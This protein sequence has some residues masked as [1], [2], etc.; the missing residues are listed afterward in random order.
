MNSRSPACMHV[1]DTGGP[2]GAE[3]V[4]SQLASRL[5]TVRHRS[6]TVVPR[7]GWLSGQLR[8]LG[9]EFRVLSRG[10]WPD[11]RYLSA[12]VR[13]ARS[14]NVRMVHSHLLGSCVYAGMLGLG[15]SLPVLGVFHGPTDFRSPGHFAAAKR[16]LIRRGVRRF[17]AVSRGTLDALAAFGVARSR[18]EVIPNGVDTAA[19]APVRAGAL[20][21]ELG[22]HDAELL[23]G[24]VGNIRAPKGYD[25]LLNTA[26][27]VLQQLSNA[28]FAIV[29]EGSERDL[30]P[31]HELRDALGIGSRVHFLGFR[32]TTAALY[33]DF[34]LFV[35]SSRSEGLPLSFLEAM[36][37]GRC[38][39]ATDSGGAKEV[40]ES[41]R[42]G[43]R[44]PIEN[45]PALAAA[46]I[47]L[48][49]DADLRH[50]LGTAGR[51][52]VLRRFSLNSTVE[53]YQQI[54]EELLDG[55]GRTNV[56]AT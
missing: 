23:I 56:A 19:F 6:I 24:S 34:D 50:R 10:G 22:L 13:L 3:T 18:I 43:L 55:A 38:V 33:C 49:R 54:Y 16:W 40:I 44:T 8:A 51:E 17:I 36:A 7:E 15:L 12:L 14:E 48:A 28:H 11:F 1:I 21:A 27:L 26:A 9:I 30:R 41:Q 46:I 35:S 32:K 47:A 53:R 25:V 31:L 45:P 42:T 20:R 4:F 39:V 5:N 2:G 29:G 52:H 37:C